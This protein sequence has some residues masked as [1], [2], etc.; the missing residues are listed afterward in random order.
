MKDTVPRLAGIDTWIFD[1]DNTLYPPGCALFDQIDRRMGGFIAELLGINEVSARALQKE[2][3][4]RHGTTLRGLML[5]HGVPPDRFLEHV[6]DVD[7]DGLAPNPDLGEALAALPGRCLVYTN[8]SA[9]HAER[10]LARLDIAQE[11]DGIFD[12]VAA[13][14]EPKPAESSFDRFLDRFAVEPGRAV[15]VEDMAR[16]LVPAAARGVTTVWLR[17]SYAWGAV[18]HQP[19]AVDYEIADLVTFLNLQA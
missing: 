14:Y 5:E 12:L 15:M 18:D 16:N 2:Y 19:A 3:F 11:I 1:L 4:L 13:D 17:T 9:R 6:H 7:L 8:G 10:V